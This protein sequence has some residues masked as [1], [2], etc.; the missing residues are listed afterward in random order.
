MAATFWSAAMNVCSLHFILIFIIIIVS[1]LSL[2]QSISPQN[3]QTFYPFFLPPLQPPRIP[4]RRRVFQP[5]PPPP[6][7]PDA[8]ALPPPPPLLLPQPPSTPSRKAVGTAIGV[9]AASTV[10]LSALFFFLVLWYLRSRREKGGGGAISAAAVAAAA[11]GGGGESNENKP[12]GTGDEFLRF[13]GNLKAVIVDE[14]GLDVLYWRKLEGGEGKESFDR[15]LFS[16]IESDRKDDDKR[17]I[18]RG[19]GRKKP[20]PPVQEIPLLR[21]KSSTSQHPVWAEAENQETDSIPP[22]PLS[23]QAIPKTPSPPPSPPKP[24]TLASSSSS[25]HG[26]SGNEEEEEEK[27]NPLHLDNVDHSS[28]DWNKIQ[29]GSYKFDGDLMEALFGTVATNRKSPRTDSTSASTPR[30]IAGPPSQIFILETKKSQEFAAVIKSLDATRKEIMNVL[31]KGVGLDTKTLEKLSR[32]AITEA[33]ESDILGFEGPP[34]R[35]ADA[36]S[37]LFFIL[38]PFPSAF[39]RFNAMFLRSRFGSEIIHVKAD[40][41]TLESACNELRNSRLFVKLLEAILKAWN[42]MNVEGSSRGNGHGFK[43]SALRKLVGVKSGDGKITVLQF[44]VQELIRAEGKRCVYTR[45]SRII[46]NVAGGG[47]DD[48][49]KEYMTLGL[50]VVGGLSSE[51]SG[52]KKAAGIDYDS[53]SA[54]HSA[55]SSKASE[56]GNLAAQCG[57]DGGGF[58]AG[59]RRFLGAAEEEME[60]I[61]EEE[62]RVMEMVKKTTEYYQRGSSNDRTWRPLQV[63]IIVKDFLGMIDEACVEI[64]RNLQRKRPAGSSSSSSLPSRTVRFPK[65]PADFLSEE[66]DSSS[67]S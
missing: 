66:G 10:V 51:L 15:Q 52:V 19:G 9:T 21:G 16:N 67:D 28:M 32:L 35:L 26:V 4:T 11:D 30:E 33:E 58:A 43:L 8:E 1:P 57:D 3:I 49:E 36:E 7:P 34:T 12:A 24:D 54:A 6:P 61:R 17:M 62:A 5:P 59:M 25:E 42:R 53:L 39:H 37:F 46:S 2:S 48:R 63:F 60:A 40:L 38:K 20:G 18:A 31:D 29:D 56:I 23:V 13:E 22:P 45:D 44:V 50:P 14:D 41:Q 65:L 55:L 27:L 47:D 64:A